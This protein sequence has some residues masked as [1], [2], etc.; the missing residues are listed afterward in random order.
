MY[1]IT[2]G[3]SAHEWLG[4]WSQRQDACGL[5]SRGSH[6]ATIAGFHRHRPADARDRHGANTAMFAVVYGVL[7]KAL[8]YRD[9]DRLV[10]IGAETYYGG[11]WQLANY[12]ASELAAWQSRRTAFER[13][14]ASAGM[15]V[16][17]R[18]P[19]GSVSIDGAYV[20]SIVR[21]QAVEDAVSS[22]SAQPAFR[23][24][25]AGAMAAI[26]ILL[27]LVGM[28]GVISYSVSQRTREIGVCMAVGAST[29]AIRRMVIGEAVQ[30][31]AA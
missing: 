4:H 17:M 27:S 29:G 15:P 28:T 2:D 1:T 24:L 6:A 5:G 31:G 30:V 16:A 18:Q 12:S 26:A 3:A 11:A 23:T 21:L 20:S 22:A 9:P 8:P 19:D 10:S 7:L 13:V 14:A 25:A